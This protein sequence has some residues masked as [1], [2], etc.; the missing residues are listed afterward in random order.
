MTTHLRSGI[1]AELIATEGEG[2]MVGDDLSRARE[3]MWYAV[4]ASYVWEYWQAYDRD[5][6][7]E[8]LAF[9]ETHDPELRGEIVTALEGSAQ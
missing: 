2:E 3:T 5:Q 6:R 4:D 7:E 8:I 1:P 9:L